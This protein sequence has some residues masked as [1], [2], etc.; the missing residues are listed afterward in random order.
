MPTR[1]LR[2][3]Q[4]CESVWGLCASARAMRSPVLTC[5][6]LLHCHYAKS[7]TD[8][9]YTATVSVV[10]SQQVATPLR[11]IMLRLRYAMPGTDIAYGAMRASV[12]T[13]RTVLV[14]CYA[15]PGTDLAYGDHLSAY[16]LAMRCLV[17]MSRML[18][19]NGA[20]VVPYQPS[21]PAT[22]YD[23]RYYPM[24]SLFD[25]RSALRSVQYYPT[26]FQ[27]SVQY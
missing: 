17:L 8:L 13:M 14:V 21:L 27:R 22:R 26:R 25:V 15:M 2:D 11:A 20:I 19:G 18:L 10:G 3:V 4:Y 1:V 24:H 9:A 23:V 7:G 16:A 12:L 5:R 6:M